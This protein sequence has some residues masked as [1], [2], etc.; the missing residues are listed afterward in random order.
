MSVQ[1]SAASPA[2]TLFRRTHLKSP[3]RWLEKSVSAAAAVKYAD[4]TEAAFRHEQHLDALRLPGRAEYLAAL[5]DAVTAVIR[6][7][8]PPL[9][10]LLRAESKWRKITERFGVE[11]QRAAYRHEL[12]VE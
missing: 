12:G 7:R 11:R 10:A 4:A 9:E 8:M 6:D 2:T 5:D 1:V 3:G